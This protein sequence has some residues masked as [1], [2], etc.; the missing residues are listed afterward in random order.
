MDNQEI[1]QSSINKPITPLINF[2]ATRWYNSLVLPNH[3]IQFEYNDDK[4]E[5]LLEK[6][7]EAIYFYYGDFG[8]DCQHELI[9]GPDQKTKQL[10]F[11]GRV[12]INYFDYQEITTINSERINLIEGLWPY[13]DFNALTKKTR[14][15]INKEIH[16]SS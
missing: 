9:I 8:K 3:I 10:Y 16:T 14:R 5:F 13:I 7:H 4:R 6:F 1:L 2:F 12:A 15:I 11:I